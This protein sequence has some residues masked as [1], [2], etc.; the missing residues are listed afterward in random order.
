MPR[1]ELTP[2]TPGF[3]GLTSLDIILLS[4]LVIVLA[5]GTFPVRWRVLCNRG[6][7][8]PLCP[9][10][11]TPTAVPPSPTPINMP[12]VTH[13]SMPTQTLTAGPILDTSSPTPMTATTSPTP[14][15]TPTS[16]AT[17]VLGIENIKG[18]VKYEVITYTLTVKNEGPSTPATA[19]LTSA[20]DPAEAVTSAGGTDCDSLSGGSVT[21]TVPSVKVSYS[22]VLTAYIDSD[23]WNI[24]SDSWGIVT[25]TV[26]ITGTGEAINTNPNNSV[27]ITVTIAPAFPEYARVVY[28]QSDRSTHHLGL[29]TSAGRVINGVLHLRAA[30]P[31]WSPD[32]TQIAFFGEE[33]ISE[34]G[35]TYQGGNGIWIIDL[36]T[37]RARQPVQVDHVKNITWSPDGTKLAFE[38]SQQ[39]IIQ[40]VRV[41]DT[42]GHEISRFPGQQPAWARDSTRLAIRNCTLGSGL[43][44]VN[45]DGS[46]PQFLT[47][48][49][50]DSY[51][52]WSP[53]GQYLAFT[54][55]RQDDDWEIYLLRLNDRHLRR[56]THRPGSDVTPVFS[57]N[58]REI[59]LRTDAFGDW[60][61]TVRSLVTG[62][63][64]AV[65][66]GV[67]YSNDWGLARPAVY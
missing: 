8:S 61:I 54:S 49:G 45:F 29:V 40:E 31:A 67:G 28:A 14:T 2:H 56:L 39:D 42:S 51:P 12:A 32:R 1:R 11:E 35:P 5:A 27:E 46:N 20:F 4:L 55:R 33:G 7:S 66:T 64:R 22:L 50:T 6:D 52:A 21:C 60:R 9:E 19:T 57:R 18:E 24:D 16:V 10:P 62:E 30:A 15:A 34:L 36:Q 47:R 26:T 38:V 44:Q 23:Y 63:E 41:V 48:D 59:Y 25:N 37:R 13:T 43:C 53:D 3:L 17:T 58:G 65:K